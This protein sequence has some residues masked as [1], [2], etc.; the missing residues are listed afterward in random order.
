MN[1]RSY[2]EGCSPT[3]EARLLNRNNRKLKHHSQESV[4]SKFLGNATHNQLV[5]DR[6]DQKCDEHG[7][8]LGEVTPRGPVYVTEEEVMHWNVPLTREFH[9]NAVVSIITRWR[10]HRWTH[11]SQEF[12]QSA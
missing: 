6:A 2:I 9:P 8:R 10:A 7:H 4:S 12:H 1:K 11:Q 5:E 3:E